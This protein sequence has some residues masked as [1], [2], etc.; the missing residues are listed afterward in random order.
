[1]AASLLRKSLASSDGAAR[2]VT[3]IFWPIKKVFLL[4]SFDW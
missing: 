1:M 4:S 2:A 3:T